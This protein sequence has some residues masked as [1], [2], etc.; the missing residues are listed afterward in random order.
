GDRRESAAL[1][2]GPQNA[3]DSMGKGSGA[4]VGVAP[5]N[6]S[7]TNTHEAGVDEPDLVKTDGR[8]IV[9]LSAGVLRVVETAGRYVSGTLD[10]AGLGG[11]D[12][13]VLR[14]V[15]ADLLLAGDLALILM[16]QEY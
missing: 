12:N 5:P 8:R 3:G 10:L 2:P 11:D 7:G 16:N 13:Q 9:T 1:P 14:Y 4:S 15:A 6:Y